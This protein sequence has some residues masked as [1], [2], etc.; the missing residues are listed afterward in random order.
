MWSFV[1]NHSCFGY[2]CP[3]KNNSIVPKISTKSSFTPQVAQARNMTI[4]TAIVPFV[5]KR[6]HF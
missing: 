2:W 6:C 3:I 1:N 4:G 5:N